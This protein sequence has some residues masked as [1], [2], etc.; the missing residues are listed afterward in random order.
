MS[1]RVSALLWHMSSLLLYGV[2]LS[3]SVGFVYLVQST[4]FTIT[5]APK[6]KSNQNIL[7][8]HTAALHL[9]NGG[10]IQIFILYVAKSIKIFVFL[11]ILTVKDLQNFP[12]FCLKV[13][14]NHYTLLM[15]SPLVV[16][17]Q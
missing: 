16:L 5:G 10:K 14:E 8:F 3:M 9:L 2:S 15:N 6:I 13:R 12:I 11:D 4:V 7:S 1:W 17:S